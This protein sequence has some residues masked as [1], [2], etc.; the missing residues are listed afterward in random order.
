MKLRHK[1]ATLLVCI[2]AGTIA[3]LDTQSQGKLPPCPNSVKALTWTNCIGTMT[4]YDSSRYIG[5]WVGG[6][7]E[8]QGVLYHA[9]GSVLRTGRWKRGEYVQESQVLTTGS[10]AQR[11]ERLSL[12]EAKTKC[13]ELGF[14]PATEAFG[15]CVLQL[16]K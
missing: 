6:L 10:D 12:T 7:P 8:G 9:D 1:A 3:S 5:E 11:S 4:Y 15:K 14:K 2:T 16:S 13:A